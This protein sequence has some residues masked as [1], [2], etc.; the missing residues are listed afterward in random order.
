MMPGIE[1]ELKATIDQIG[2]AVETLRKAQD[3][4]LKE[5]KKGMA[6]FIT[7]DKLAKINKSVDDLIDAKSK[8]EKDIE[9]E[10]KNSDDLEKKFNRLS[11][12]GSRE[13]QE[14]EQKNLAIFNGSRKAFAEQYGT[15][16]SGKA[17]PAD[18]TVEEMRAYKSAFIKMTR[19]VR[20]ENL[21]DDERK[22]M[23][24]G[25]D[26][27]GGYLVTPDLSGRIVQKIY[28]TSPMRQVASQQTIGTNELDGLYDTDEAASGGWVSETGARAASAS[29]TLGKYKIPVNEVFAMPEATQQLLDDANIDVEA[30][31]GNKVADKLTRVENAAFVTGTG[32]GQPRGFTTYTNVATADASRTWGQLEMMKTTV[33]GDFAASSPADILFNLI[34]AFKNGYLN[35]ATWATTREVVAKIRKFKE[36]TTNAYMWQPGL[37]QGQPEQLLGYPIIKFQDMP[38]LSSNSVSLALGDFQ[39]AY[40]IVDRQGFR[41]LRDPYTNKPYV[42]FYTTRR[43]GGQ[44]VQFEALKFIQFST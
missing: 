4:E 22:A 9:T 3:D 43:T 6:D 14:L 16:A 28:E 41:V 13:S 19:G 23:T 24:S 25:S 12:G 34:A 38:A 40:Q 36:S 8:L 15:Q 10:K 5:V 7:A 30:W 2:V 37:Q 35:N 39:M 32:V 44:V 29:P 27:E 20:I 33:N 18:A 42:R 31:L 17:A 21:A 26:N 1:E 11:L